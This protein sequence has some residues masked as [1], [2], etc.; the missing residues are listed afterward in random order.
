VVQNGIGIETVT[1]YISDTI[2]S[3]GSDK[4]VQSGFGAAPKGTVIAGL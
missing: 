2:S 4:Q 3:L 1:K